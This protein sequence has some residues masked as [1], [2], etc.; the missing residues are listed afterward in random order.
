MPEKACEL[1]TSGMQQTDII[2]IGAGICGLSTASQLAAKGKRILILEARNRTGGRVETQIGKF[3]NTLQ[4]G[5][6]F[7][8]G[9]LPLSKAVIK[10]AGGTSVEHEGEMYRSKDGQIFPIKDFAPYMDEFMSKLGD[11][12]KDTNLKDFLDTYFNKKKYKELRESVTLT[13]EGFDAADAKRISAKSLF[14]E[15]NSDSMQGA[16]LLKE[17]YG[18]VVKELTQDCISNGAELLFS[19]TAKKIKWKK[20]KVS[21]ICND[22]TSY[23]AKQVIITVSLGVLTSKTKD[24]ANIQFSPAIPSKIKAARDMGFGAV[25][26][27][28]VECKTRFWKDKR[29]TQHVQQIPDLAFLMNDTAF[30]TLWFSNENEIPLITCWAGGGRTKKL[31]DLTNKQLEA[32][33]L[34]ALAEAFNCSKHFIRSQLAGISVFNWAKDDYAKGAYSYTTLK[35]EQSKKIMSAPLLNTVFF[36]GEALGKT[37]GTV[38]AALESAEELAKLVNAK[39]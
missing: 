12:K 10:K 25:I 24:K 20:G 27:V 6:E 36:G 8:H 29:F 34:E 16:S 11:L 26:K 19:K 39:E 21:V 28:L 7:I 35:T 9:D 38:E 30:P 1:K 15:W 37:S 18:I 13:A 33:T 14:E 3:G 23:E 22:G 5:P 2:I 31:E 4:A 32:K 17:G